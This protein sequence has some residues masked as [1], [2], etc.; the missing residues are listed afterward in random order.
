[1]T[2]R[3]ISDIRVKGKRVLVR[4]DFN[5]PLEDGRIT[6]DRRI[7]ESLRTINYLRRGG[8]RVILASHLGRPA[9]KVTD[10]LRLDPVAQR[11]GELLGVPVRKLPDCVGPEVEAAVAAL[12]DG[13]V[14]LLEN[15]RFHPG[16][17]AND[18]TFARRLASLADVFVNDAFGAAHRAHASTVGVA[19]HLPAVAGFLM[20]KELVNLSR[21]LE[22]PTRPFAAILGGKK[23]S[24]KIGVIRNLL[25][26]ADA[27]LIGGAMA[28]TFLFAKGYSVGASLCEEDKVDLARSLMDEARARNVGFHLPEDVVVADRFADDAKHNIVSADAIPEGWMGMD[29]GPKT[30]AA[31][32]K[33]ILGARTVI[34]NGPMGVFEIPAFAGGTKAIA[35]A[36]AESTAV[37]IV[38]GGDTAAAVEQIGL[39]ERMTHISTGGG[40]SLEFMEGRELPGVAVLQEK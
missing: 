24:D 12:K 27:L 16:E 8:A 18:E 11:L 10:E 9:G 5:V 21:A 7:T 22:S 3:T 33:I 37:T 29:I 1:M 28:Y 35:G 4:V 36:M 40:A 19:R 2:K 23:V 17:E 13:D 39:A 38:G 6:D 25:A 34:W 15:L 31:Y 32:R 20:E 26:K 14:V 30:S